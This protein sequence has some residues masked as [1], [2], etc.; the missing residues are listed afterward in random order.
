MP[1]FLF[2]AIFA[3]SQ[4]SADLQDFHGIKLHIDFHYVLILFTQSNLGK[5]RSEL[6]HLIK[7]RAKKLDEIKQSIKVIKVSQLV[8]KQVL[9]CGPGLGMCPSTG[10]KSK[11]KL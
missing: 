5:K 10:Q 1:D 11:T 7:E 8:W 3:V 2:L 4:D 6:K 9:F